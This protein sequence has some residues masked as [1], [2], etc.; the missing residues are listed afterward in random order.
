[1]LVQ[2]GGGSTLLFANSRSLPNSILS[3]PIIIFTSDTE[4]KNYGNLN[5]KY[6]NSKYNNEVVNQG[7]TTTI[8]T[9][10][11]Y[12]LRSRYLLQL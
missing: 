6:Y 2:A 3:H 10:I 9:I 8:V 4:L 12:R 11:V 7:T 5:L 1:M